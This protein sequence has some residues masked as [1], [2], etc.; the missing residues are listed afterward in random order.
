MIFTLVLWAIGILIFISNKYN[1][2]N[3]WLAYCYFVTSIGTFKEFLVKSIVPIL[4]SKYPNVSADVYITVDSCLTAIL[5]LF[6][7]FCFITMSMYFSG[8][9]ETNKNYLK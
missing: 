8:I 9:K 6:T 7:P 4:I 2:T 5:Y 3:R 1:K